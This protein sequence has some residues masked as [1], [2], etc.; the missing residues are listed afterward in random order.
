MRPVINLINYLLIYLYYSICKNGRWKDQ[1]CPAGMIYSETNKMCRSDPSCAHSFKCKA[2]ESYNLKCDEYLICTWKGMFEHRF[3][4]PFHRWDNREK[5]CISDANC[6]PFSVS[7][8]EPCRDGE[9]I[10]SFDCKF[11]HQCSGGKWY[12]MICPIY[13]TKI[14]ATC[15]YVGNDSWLTEEKCNEGDTVANPQDCRSYAICDA[16]RWKMVTCKVGTFWDQHLKRCRYST[17][18]KAMKR[19]ECGHGQY[20]VGG[21]RNEYLKCLDGSWMT[22]KCPSGYAFN[23]T[24]K[25]CVVSN[26]CVPS[27]N[28]Y[29][30]LIDHGITDSSLLS[31]LETKKLEGNEHLRKFCQFGNTV[32]NEY[33]CNRY[34]ECVMGEYK[35][36]YCENNYE[37]NDASGRCEKEYQCD[38]SRCR[39]GRTIESEICGHYQ[40]CFNG[41][42]HKR[43]CEGNQRFANG[44]C[45]DTYCN[46]DND[47]TLSVLSSS[48]KEGDILAD[49]IDCSRYF[50]CRHGRFQEQF[51]WNGSSFDKKSGHCV[52]DTIC[53]LEK[54]CVAGNMKDDKQDRTAYQICNNGKFE[55]RFCPYGLVYSDSKR[56]C[57]K[58]SSVG[59]LIFDTCKEGAY[60]ADPMDCHKFYQC[61]H[62]K[63]VSKTCPSKLYW[64]AKKITCDWLYDNNSCRNHITYI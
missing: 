56:R 17:D 30:N 9:V 14:C 61:V 58:D 2:G 36:R 45:Q 55:S 4:P 29:L 62:G 33:D 25:M 32:R 23:I 28:I 20:L 27:S 31:Q 5:L 21:T 11:Y 59:D 52:R 51:C 46:D 44:Y 1:S 54:I 53:M 19:V 13:P 64:N 49:D 42:W 41:K 34:F 57:E 26:D 15:R 50:I 8:N 60:R 35:D 24:T 18:C 40:I 37:F 39:N 3:C 22:M 7:S 10:D 47:E 12:K 48:C 38:L 6:L 63:W 16:R 43:V